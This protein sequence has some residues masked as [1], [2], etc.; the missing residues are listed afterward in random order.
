MVITKNLRYFSIALVLIFSFFWGTN[1]LGE[2][3]ETLFYW[4][5]FTNNP[6]IIAAQISQDEFNQHLRNLKPIRDY[7]IEDVDI[8]SRAVMSLLLNNH[9]VEKIL[10]EKN[11]EQQLPIASL[12]KLMTA[13]VVLKNY[14]LAKEIKISKEAV[15]QE[16][17]FG[18][19]AVGSVLTVTDL[20]YPLLMESSNDAAFSLANDYDG[21]SIENFIDMMNNEAQNLG[22]NNTYF[23][24]PTGLDPEEYEP[25]DK[26][27]LSTARDLITLVED[28]LNEPLIWE[29]LTTEQT[30]F[31]GPL[32]IN[33]NKLLRKMPGIVGGKTGFTDEALGCF[34]LVTEAPKGKGVLINVILGTEHRFSEMQKLVN[35]VRKA[36]KW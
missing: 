6:K 28:L 10:L 4:R 30:S 31:Y 2:N 11:T 29:V 25:M 33:T 9:G 24:N 36:Y 34:M 35:W 14:L 21:I 1:V 18:N 19:L 15:S 27:N 32:L 23:V 3:L 8:N 7:S 20:L 16:E 26:I 12:T 5:Q 17:N 13:N 22:L